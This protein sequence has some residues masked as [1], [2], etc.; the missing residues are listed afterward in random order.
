[1]EFE[2]VTVTLSDAL[3]LIVVVA[4]PQWVTL[5]RA[6]GETLVEREPLPVA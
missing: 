4:V 1:M 6:Q 5:T 2:G 3:T